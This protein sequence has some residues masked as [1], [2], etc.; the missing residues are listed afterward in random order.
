M[1]ITDD[2]YRDYLENLL[3]GRRS[4]CFRTV[5]SLLDNGVELKT[6]YLDLFQRSLY[7]V[8]DQWESNRI[9]VST[10]HLAT[11]ITESLL[12][13]AYPRLF[14]SEKKRSPRCDFLHSQ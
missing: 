4:V 1:I 3:K 12:P 6:L 8:G 10:E 13:L 11:A 14:S 7:E 2:L 9:S 5:S